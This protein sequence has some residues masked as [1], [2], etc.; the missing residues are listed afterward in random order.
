[1]K[2]KKRNLPLLVLCLL[3][4]LMLAACGS[5]EE[6]AVSASDAEAEDSEEVSSEAEDSAEEEDSSVED[7]SVEEEITIDE[8]FAD[9]V[10]NGEGICLK[11][12]VY[13]Q[14]GTPVRNGLVTISGEDQTIEEDTDY[15]GYA[16]IT[17]L[18]ADTDYTMT[19][20]DRNEE[21]VGTVPLTII[22]GDTYAGVL[23]ETGEM[24]LS[25]ADGA[26]SVADVSIVATDENAEDSA[27]D[28]YSM[29]IWDGDAVPAQ[30]E[31]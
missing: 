31:T 14:K 18:L 16:L 1:M 24:V 10:A 23:Q 4:A 19:V 21:L 15:D 2:L 6:S 27:F 8:M 20:T 25:V 3:L 22:E 26:V 28:C 12:R 30:P 11:L 7:S 17:G 5:S 29:D 9:V 13:N